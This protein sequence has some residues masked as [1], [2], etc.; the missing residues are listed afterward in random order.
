[1]ALFSSYRLNV[2][3]EQFQA[4]HLI[5]ARVPAVGLG[6]GHSAAPARDGP[7]VRGEAAI[8]AQGRIFLK[9]L[10][11]EQDFQGRSE[12]HSGTEQNRAAPSDLDTEHLVIGTCLTQP[13]AMFRTVSIT[14]R[15]EVGS[16]ALRRLTPHST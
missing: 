7:V 3:L 8:S 16:I 10:R 11:Y 9:L 6:Q 4:A 15:P 13:I 1:M 5:E 14:S 12:A 2:M